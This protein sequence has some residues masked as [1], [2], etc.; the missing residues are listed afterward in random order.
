MRQFFLG[1][2]CLQELL[3]WVKWHFNDVDQLAQVVTSS[4][5]PE[6]H[7]DYWSTV[8]STLFSVESF[9]LSLT[10]YLRHR[11]ILLGLLQ[12]SRERTWG[13]M[14]DQSFLKL[15]NSFLKTVTKIE[16]W[17]GFKW[18]KGNERS[19]YLCNIFVYLQIYGFVAQGRL[20]EVVDLLSFHPYK[21][22]GKFDVR[23]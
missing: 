7:Q 18:S 12:H 23:N 3:H 11:S 14:D 17:A 13:Y 8:G 22:Q 15:K 5:D 19:E 16:I 9:Q 4:E 2:Y 20:T 6:A 10:Q 21:E 1:G